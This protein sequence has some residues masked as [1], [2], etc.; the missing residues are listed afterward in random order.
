VRRTL[1]LPLPDHS[2]RQWA[3]E[4][5][6]RHRDYR[7]ET[8][9]DAIPED[10]IESF[11]Y[12]LNQ[13]A[14]D[15]P[16]GEIEF[17]PEAITPDVLRQ[18]EKKWADAGM[19][20][21]T[22]VAINRDGEAVAQSTLGVSADDDVNIPQW[23]TLVR[24]EDRGHRLGLA[25]KVRNLQELQGTNLPHRRIVTCNAETNAQMVGINELLGFRPV[26]LMAQ[27]QLRL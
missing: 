8:F 13:L 4:A 21:F 27:F 22:T 1:D 20:F 12:V 2:L 15:A 14:V 11:C 18:R 3:E 10:I 26:E 19:R 24:R 16:T 9:T 7:L 17:E 25:I 5:E 23:G 6:P